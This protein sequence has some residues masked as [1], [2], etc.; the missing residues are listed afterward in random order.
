MTAS[1]SSSSRLATLKELDDKF[2]IS[3]LRKLDKDATWTSARKDE[4]EASK[5]LELQQRVDRIRERLRATIEVKRARGET[6]QPAAT[7]TGKET[8]APAEEE[9]TAQGAIES[10]KGS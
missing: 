6:E 8:E 10:P 9:P 3:S 5:D 7:V 2:N 1:S 4:E